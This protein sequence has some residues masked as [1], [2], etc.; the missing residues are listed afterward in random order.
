MVHLKSIWE[1]SWSPCGVCFGVHFGPSAVHFGVQ[2]ESMLRSDS[3]FGVRSPRDQISKA[4]EPILALLLDPNVG[5]VLAPCWRRSG[6]LW[7]PW[8]FLD[9]S[10]GHL[11]FNFDQDGKRHDKKR[12]DFRKKAFKITCF[13]W[14]LKVPKIAFG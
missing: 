3:G 10:K 11:E 4:L 13:Q 8:A 7:R 14:F 5:P 6:V 12:L 9:R 2:F 1:L